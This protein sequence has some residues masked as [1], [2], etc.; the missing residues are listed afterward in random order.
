M[1]NPP[2]PPVRGLAQDTL[3]QYLSRQLAD[4]AYA[5]GVKL[6]SE[7]ELS[8]LFRI[9][10]GSVRKVLEAF[11]A[12]G[13]L[14]RAAGSGTFVAAVPAADHGAVVPR[15]AVNTVS[16]AELMEARLLFEPLLPALIV[17]KATA[18]DFARMD[19]CLAEA[20]RATSFEEF[21]YWDGALHEALSQA[22]HNGFLT[23]TLRLMTEVRDTGEWGRLKREALSVE[24]RQRYQDQHR[25]LVAAL[26]DRD[27]SAASLILREHL[28]EVQANLLG[29]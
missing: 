8:L 28:R 22:A 25:A 14:R 5:L 4:G 1:H 23:L 24:R 11:I 21:E 16:P 19:H 9:S 27:E 7:R 18:T 20:E 15:A 2:L 26:R 13:I 6:P 29:A 10:R 17:R 3:T 12:Q